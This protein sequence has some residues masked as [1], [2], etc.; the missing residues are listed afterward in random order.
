MSDVRINWKSLHIFTRGQSVIPAY[1]CMS[2]N[3]NH[4]HM[5]TLFLCCDDRHQKDSSSNICE[6]WGCNNLSSLL[7]LTIEVFLHKVVK[8]GLSV[9]LLD[10]SHVRV[11]ANE[12][13][14][15]AEKRMYANRPFF[16]KEAKI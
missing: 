9:V 11:S 15:K 12:R 3:L 6:G 8:P 10:R 16:G 4:I 2:K 7:I 14:G 1:Y 13:N 5:H